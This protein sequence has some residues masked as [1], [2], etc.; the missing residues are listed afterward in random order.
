MDS[1]APNIPEFRL[2]EKV[3]SDET[4]VILDMGVDIRYNSPDQQPQGA[5]TTSSSTRSSS[6]WEPRAAR[7]SRCRV[8]TTK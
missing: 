5:A 6:A 8:A 4:Q 7:V 2:P 1:C 3:L